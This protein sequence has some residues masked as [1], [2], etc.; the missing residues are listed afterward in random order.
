[1]RQVYFNHST[2]KAFTCDS[3]YVPRM[4]EWVDLSKS[5][6]DIFEIVTILSDPIEHLIFIGVKPITQQMK[7]KVMGAPEGNDLTNYGADAKVPAKEP[8]AGSPAVETTAT[9]TVPPIAE[10]KSAEAASVAQPASTNE[11]KPEVANG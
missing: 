8:A 7:G 4:G 11:L 3:E 5:G 1:M 6:S 10:E 9:E 2:K